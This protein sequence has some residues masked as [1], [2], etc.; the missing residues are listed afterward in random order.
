MPDATIHIASDDAFAQCI[1]EI[2]PTDP[3]GFERK[4]DPY[5]TKPPSNPNQ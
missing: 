2:A 5:M 4:P 3:A 1:F